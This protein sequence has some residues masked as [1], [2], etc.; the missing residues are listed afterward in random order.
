MYFKRSCQ[1]NK[2]QRLV[3]LKSLFPFPNQRNKLNTRQNFLL[4]IIT[5]ILSLYTYA[6]GYLQ[7][8]NFFLVYLEEEDYTKLCLGLTPSYAQ[9][10]LLEMFSGPCTVPGFETGSA[11]CTLLIV[12]NL[13][14]PKE[15]VY[16]CII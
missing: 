3:H 9:G 14:S 4:K 12:H 6:C 1:S 10:S 8:K 15:N 16:L 11:I 5:E 2:L 13:S 7:R